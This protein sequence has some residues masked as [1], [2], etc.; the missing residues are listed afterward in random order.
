MLCLHRL[1]R[2]RQVGQ[3]RRR[4]VLYIRDRLGCTTLTVKNDVVENF[5]VRTS[6]KTKEILS[7]FTKD[8][9]AS[10]VTVM[11]CSRRS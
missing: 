10:K 11:H 2:E 8:R 6:T 1:L 9:C 3:A 4:G 5:W 7:E